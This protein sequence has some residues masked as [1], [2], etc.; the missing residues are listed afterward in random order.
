M[1]KLLI[2]HDS[3]IVRA[4]FKKLLDECVVFDYDIVPSY[5]EAKALLSRSRY[6]YAIVDRVLKDALNGEIIALFNKHYVA[7]LV[8]TNE[9]NEDFFDDFE[10]A[11]IVDYIKK[12][13]RNDEFFAIDKLLQLRENKNT[14]VLI[15]SDSNVYSSYLKHNLNLHNFKVFNTLNDE[16]SYKKIDLH[17]DI[18][19]VILDL[20]SSDERSLKLVEYI[21]NV[22]TAKELKIIVL[23]NESSSYQTSLLLSSGADD[24]IVKEFSRDE[25]YVRVYQNINKV[26]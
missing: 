19:L 13:K 18:S 4:T 12:I 26:C 20:T 24:Y 11:N 14:T 7:P 9:I 2:V 16:N 8:F 5:E 25:F 23:A 15:V 10:G 22:K 1:S 3:V 17:S 21:R 6:E